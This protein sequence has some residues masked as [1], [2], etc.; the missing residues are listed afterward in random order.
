MVN[1]KVL[2]SALLASAAA[3]VLGSAVAL[4]AGAEHFPGGRRNLQASF[5][6]SCWAGSRHSCSWP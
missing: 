6:L 5:R 2:M 3:L 1:R 4:A